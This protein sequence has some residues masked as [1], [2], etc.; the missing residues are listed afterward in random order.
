MSLENRNNHN[1]QEA[2]GDA[3]TGRRNGSGSLLTQ[4]SIHINSRAAEVGKQIAKLL[5][6]ICLMGTSFQIKIQLQLLLHPS[7]SS[8]VVCCVVDP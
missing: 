5:E 4:C 3:I 1:N 2:P 7:V 6:Y 8:C